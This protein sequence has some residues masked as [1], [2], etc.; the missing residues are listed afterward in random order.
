M[1][2]NIEVFFPTCCNDGH[3]TYFWKKYTDADVYTVDIDPYCK[4][5]IEE[6][7]RLQSVNATTQDAIEYAKSFDKKIDLLFLDAWDLI[8]NSNYAEKH[9]EVY[10]I[11]REK[12]S[13]SC[14][15]LIDDT[16]VGCGGKGALLIPEL[17]KD[18][19]QC[20][21]NKRQTLFVRNKTSFFDVVVP[22]GPNDIDLIDKQIE[23][24]KKNVIGFRNIYLISSDD[25]LNVDGCI[26]ISESIFPFSIKTIENFHGKRKRSETH[27]N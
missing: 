12:L 19:F 27:L 2:H 16:D 6:D 4:R 13:D 21:V 5:I 24:V 15:I 9:L 20:L 10:S 11:L 7:T 14:L 25:N 22:V 3:S 8:P 17:K 1:N 23:Y 18:G 26:S